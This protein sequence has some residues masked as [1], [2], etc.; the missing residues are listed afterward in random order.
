MIFPTSRRLSSGSDTPD[1]NCWNR[2]SISRFSSLTTATK[3]LLWTCWGALI[4]SLRTPDRGLDLPERSSP[5]PA[6]HV[7][8]AG[9]AV[10]RAADVRGRDEAHV[11]P[12]DERLHR[13]VEVVEDLVIVGNRQ[14]RR[15][16]GSP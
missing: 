1:S 2:D 15:S 13:V 3:R 14:Q 5:R 6:P 9:A 7:E 16:R 11:D 8:P 10:V 12:A 4:S